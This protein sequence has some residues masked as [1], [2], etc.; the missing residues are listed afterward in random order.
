M[1]WSLEFTRSARRSLAALPPEEREAVRRALDRLLQDPGAADFKK[2]AGRRDEWRLRVGRWR[3]VL[4]LD[5]ARGQMTILRI[6]PRDRA[7]RA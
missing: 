6:E 2:L 4:E 1:P 5:N 3:V 7:Y